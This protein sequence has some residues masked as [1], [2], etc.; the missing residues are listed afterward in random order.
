MR[1]HS[2]LF[3][4]IVAFP[5]LLMAARLAQRGKRFKTSTARFNFFLERELGRLQ[6]ELR[7]KRYPR[8]SITSFASMNPRS[9]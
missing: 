1:R 3:E 6:W 8:A 2:R 4:Q 7:T 5:N 9:E